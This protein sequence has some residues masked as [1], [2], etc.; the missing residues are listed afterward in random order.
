VQGI[1]VEIDGRDAELPPWH[2]RLHDFVTRVLRDTG[3]EEG[4][5]S[6]VLCSDPFIREL[7][8]RYRDIDEATDVLSFSQSEG[9][10]MGE[11]EHPVLGDIVV[12]LEAVRRQARE[13]GVPFGEELKRVVVHGILHVQGMDHEGNNEEEE[14]KLKK[15]EELLRMYS[16]VNLF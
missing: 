15:Q 5:I 6:V 3:V 12:S 9:Y 16:G 8:G 2:A 11:A 10:D 1:T 13:Y 7:N 4:E 14:P